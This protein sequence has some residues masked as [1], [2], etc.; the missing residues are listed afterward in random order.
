M[1]GRQNI[2]AVVRLRAPDCLEETVKWHTSFTHTIHTQHNIEKKYRKYRKSSIITIIFIV[3]F[4]S[5]K[6]LL[7]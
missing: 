3:H 5:T 1:R 7:K 6:H 4:V 2:K